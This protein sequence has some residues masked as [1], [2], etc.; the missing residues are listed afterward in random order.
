MNVAE[1]F[2]FLKCIVCKVAGHRVISLA[3][4]QKVHRDGCELGCRTALQKQNLVVFRDIHDTAQSGLGILN[5][6]V[7]DL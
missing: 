2:G 4:L 1:L 3:G 6:R 5:D 7:I